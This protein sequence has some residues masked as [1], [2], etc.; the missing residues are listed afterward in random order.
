MKVSTILDQIDMGVLALPEFQ[1]GYVWNREQVRE[2]VNSMYQRHPVGS[3]LVWE[4]E[5]VNAKSRGDAPLPSGTVKLILDGQQRITSLYGIIRGESPTFFDGNESAFTGLYFNIEEEIFE[6]YGPIK[7]RDNPLWISVTDLMKKGVGQYFSLL[8]K[9]ELSQKAEEYN[10]RL[11]AVANIKDI[12]LHV[13]E[14]TG[15][16]KDIDVVV[17]I[18]NKVNSQG[19]RL[20]KGDLALAKVCAEWPGARPEM[21]IRLKK[22]HSDG[23]HFK[24]DWLLRCIN[25]IT[26]GKALFD[27]LENVSPSRFKD[28]LEK[29]EK[30]IDYLLNLISSRLGLDHD[31]VIGSKY[32]FPLMV[33]YLNQRGGNIRDSREQDRLL[34]WYIHTLLWGRYSGSTETTL[35]QDLEAIEDID[36]GLNR[37]IE[38]LRRNRGDL[39][40]NPSD[41]IDWSVGARFYPILYM[42]MRVQH[43]R[44]WETGIELSDHMLGRGTSLQLHHIFPKSLLYDRGYSRPQVNQIANFTF[45]TQETNLKV[46]NKDPAIYLDRYAMEKPGVLESHWIPTD[47]ELWKL[48]NYTA[49]LEARR[50]LLAEAANHFLRSLESGSLSGLHTEKRTLEHEGPV[51]GI[52][53][54]DEEQVLLDMNI[55]I[56]EQGLPEGEFSY[57]LVDEGTGELKAILDLAWPQ[58]IQEGY[59]QPVVLLIDEDLEVE[60]MVNEAGYRFFTSPEDF[61]SYVQNEILALHQA[62]D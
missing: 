14:V 27:A 9:A 13:E 42:L 25:T 17:D 39:N 49:F 48:D 55:W 62:A 19:T 4:T 36:N 32:A 6:F 16:D 51:G 1:R 30:Y 29:A 50:K 23:F 57:E 7:M 43:A 24:L 20:S 28:G 35:N 15:K 26:T 45:L 31:R 61:R 52:I 2:F 37:L 18:F 34:F 58:G 10:N 44:D 12:D 60:K 46:S 53:S 38:L 21:K 41:F 47:S 11:N 5:T 22:W 3:L 33:K 8:S 54:S 59:S 40:I 56:V